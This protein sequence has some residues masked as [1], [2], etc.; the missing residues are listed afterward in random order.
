MNLL[1]ERTEMVCKDCGREV[2]EGLEAHF[3][4]CETKFI[5]EYNAMIRARLKHK[6]PQLTSKEDGK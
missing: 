3:H 4:M 6:R 2:G 5:N 1:I